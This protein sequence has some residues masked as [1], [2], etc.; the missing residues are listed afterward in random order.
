MILGEKN[1]FFAGIYQDQLTEKLGWDDEKN[2]LKILK[3]R[4][5]KNVSISEEIQQ[6]IESELNLETDLAG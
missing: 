5:D 3:K 6:Q 2:W 4:I 1:D